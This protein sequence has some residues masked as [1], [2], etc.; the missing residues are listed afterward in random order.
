MPNQTQPLFRDPAA[1]LADRARDLLDRLTADE[2][3][4]LLHQHQPAIERLGLA[5]FHTGAEALHGVAWLGRA[6]VLPQ[7]VGL[8]ATWDT[9]LL[10]RLGDLVSTELRAKHAQDPAVSLNVWAPVVNPLRHPAWGRGEEGYSE[11]P[12]LVSHLATAYCA[13]LRGDHP[14]VWKT[15]PALKHFLGY[16]NETDRSAT[17]SNLSERTLY[18]YELPAYRGPVEAGVAG[19][20]MPSYNLV[21]GVPAHTSG[22]L[23]AE[24][25]SWAPGSVAVVSDAGAPTFLVTV[26]RAF[27]SHAQAHAAAVRAGLDSFTDN[28]TDPSLTLDRLRE[29]LAAGLLTQED[30][31][32]AALRLLE[33]RLRTG[34]LDGSADPYAGIGPDA[35]D[36]PEHRVLAREAAAKSVVLLRN[37]GTLPLGTPGR[38]A[39]VGPLADRVLTDWYSGTPPYAV[40]LARAVADRYPDAVVDVADGAD[41]VALHATS[42]GRYVTVTADGEVSVSAPDAGPGT[43][44][45]VTDWG[46]GLLTL[47]SAA[48]G[49]LLTGAGWILAADAERVGG[50]VVQESFRRH[51]HA[52][53]TWSLL[54]VGS[55][56]W[57]RV[58]LGSGLLVAEA[59]RLVDAERFVWRTV[60]SG[61][62]EVA[63]AAAAA[64]VVL[65]AVGNDP[66]LGGRETEDRTSLALPEQMAETWRVAR[67]ACPAAVLVVTSSYPY[68]LGP[69]VMGPGVMDG[70]A[71]DDGAG[72]LVWAAHGG[73]EAGNGLVDVLSGDTEPFGRLAQTW[74]ATE[75]Q[76]GDL[77]DYD[78]ARQGVTYRHLASE[79]AYWFGH[80]LSYTT[81][82]YEG[83]RLVCDGGA[84]LERD[85]GAT[86]VVAVRNTGERPVDELVAVHG[87]SPDLPV[88]AARRQLL[89]HARVRLAP[90]ASAEVEVPLD[91][92]ALAVRHGGAMVLQ[93]GTYTVASGP[94]AG[95]LRVRAEL[96]VSQPPPSP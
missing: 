64:D 5:A 71:G 85:G 11:E 59:T 40:S 20:V 48:S 12:R 44:L 47:R 6:T 51:H 37:D 21:N 16:G 4:S 82:A 19:A 80:G 54:H 58:Q 81:V 79:P 61:H 69:G 77:F 13:G 27:A 91:L 84:G 75:A 43:H 41:R 32:T 38:I 22:D 90:G 31:D 63:R 34:E 87:L 9:D 92:G 50:W 89:G 57:V 30:V 65:V 76:A 46:D 33:L 39:V 36:L 93:P 52:D 60:V 35:I 62:A 10:R 73:Q 94:S 14:T 55:G 53:G 95:D 68:V 28:D 25:R 42:S 24:L 49:R 26:Q 15:V 72:A 29:A 1:P 23:L 83:L 8:G 86:A 66:H 96:A 18:E 78:V 2:R 74:P 70:P 17:S 67:E 56:R 88:P 45:D 3:L 7:P